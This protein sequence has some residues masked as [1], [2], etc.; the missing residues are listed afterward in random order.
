MGGDTLPLYPSMQPLLV[1]AQCVKPAP[2]VRCFASFLRYMRPICVVWSEKGSPWLLME[3]S[4]V[5][6]GLLQGRL[7][8][9]V[10]QSVGHSCIGGREWG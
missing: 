7:V 4:M 2:F 6:E 5:N 3:G 9:P 10:W 1:S 8:E